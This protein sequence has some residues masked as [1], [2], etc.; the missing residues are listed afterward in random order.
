MPIRDDAFTYDLS[1]RFPLDH[2]DKDQVGFQQ[3]HQ[4]AR[5]DHLTLGMAVGDSFKQCAEAVASE[6]ERLRENEV[7]R[8][9]DTGVIRQINAGD[10]A[11]LL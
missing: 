4:T 5:P 9:R 10:I 11:I 6:I 1:D 7:V 2:L 8:D 3:T